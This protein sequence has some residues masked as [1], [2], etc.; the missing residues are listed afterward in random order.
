MLHNIWLSSISNVC[1]QPTNCLPLSKAS[2]WVKGTETMV[3]TV[4][5]V[6]IACGGLLLPQAMKD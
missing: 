6:K 4:Q 2:P 1:D 3:L 5:A